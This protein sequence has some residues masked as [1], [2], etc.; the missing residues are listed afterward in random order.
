MSARYFNHTNFKQRGVIS[1]LVIIV[2]L[3]IVG[4]GGYFV[5][6]KNP[7]S[8]KSSVNSQKT[9]K[10]ELKTYQDNRRGF[11]VAYPEGWMVT[12]IMGSTPKDPGNP[13]EKSVEFRPPGQRYIPLFI[14]SRI[15]KSAKWN[16][17]DVK[18]D[19]EKPGKELSQ[20]ISDITINGVSGWN[21][22]AVTKNFDSVDYFQLS[23]SLLSKDNKTY[24]EIDIW[25][26]KEYPNKKILNDI[27]NS[28]K[29][30]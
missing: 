6:V 23:L 10:T 16:A 17:E 28:F 19:A 14:V 4:I 2:V 26:A 5:L 25:D 27:L 18:K 15:E 20:T 9:D 21:L 24:Y 22:S 11:S 8:P 7:L 12:E 1:P 29:I 3:A 13:N 30:L